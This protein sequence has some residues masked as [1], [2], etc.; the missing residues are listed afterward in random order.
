MSVQ[1]TQRRPVQ[2]HPRPQQHQVRQ[3]QRQA[4]AQAPKA[5]PK[6][7]GVHQQPSQYK[8]QA[9]AKG[10]ELNGAKA[11]PNANLGRRDLA[12]KAAKATKPDTTKAQEAGA[13]QQVAAQGAARWQQ[14]E[15]T[16][17]PPSKRDASAVGGGEPK[18]NYHGMPE[19]KTVEGKLQ[20]DISVKAWQPKDGKSFDPAKHNGVAL[21]TKQAN[22][23][24]VKPGDKVM[25]HDH[26]TGK[27]FEATY[28]DNA[29][30]GEFKGAM[31]HLEMTPALA[32]NMGLNVRNKSGQYQNGIT[33]SENM[34]GRFEVRPLDR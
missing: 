25:V 29:G 26:D 19:S 16:P 15:L 12:A 9:A 2:H 3:A 14:R 1:S 18:V 10:P 5:A 23:L 20:M 17:E 34:V 13:Q 7:Q 4:P 8:P 32:E 6:G 33:H 30:P 22:E 11:N 21:T 28:Y 31:Q 24:G 27:N